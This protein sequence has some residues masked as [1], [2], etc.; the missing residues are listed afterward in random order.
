[1][2]I[3]DTESRSHPLR[4]C[5]R[6]R[7]GDLA[8]KFA[9]QSEQ[10]CSSNPDEPSE[11]LNPIDQNISSSQEPALAIFEDDSGRGEYFGKPFTISY[12]I[13]LAQQCILLR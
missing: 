12:A 5:C 1:M 10:Q 4:E 2:Q 13:G 8:G 7:E 3:N 11:K 6:I 9:L